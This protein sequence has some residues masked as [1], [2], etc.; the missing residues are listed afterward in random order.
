MPFVAAERAEAKAESKE[1]MGHARGVGTKNG[2]L[3]QQDA[4]PD[5]PLET[6]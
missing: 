2:R 6:G 4:P 5:R 1:P 3:D